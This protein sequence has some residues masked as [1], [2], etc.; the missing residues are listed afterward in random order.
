MVMER[1]DDMN[2]NEIAKSGKPTPCVFNFESAIQMRK[3]CDKNTQHIIDNLL[4]AICVDNQLDVEK[5]PSSELPDEEWEI[6][7][8]RISSLKQLNQLEKQSIKQFGEIAKHA[9][10]IPAIATA[11]KKSMQIY[12]HAKSVVSSDRGYEIEDLIRYNAWFSKF[13]KGI[14]KALRYLRYMEKFY[15]FKRS[16][17]LKNRPASDPRST[18]TAFPRPNSDVN[19]VRPLPESSTS[20]PPTSSSSRSESASIA[21]VSYNV[22]DGSMGAKFREINRVIQSSNQSANPTPRT[23]APRL[24]PSTTNTEPVTAPEQSKTTSK[25]KRN[26]EKWTDDDYDAI[27]DMT[28]QGYEVEEIAK[29]MNRS[30]ASIRIKVWQ[31]EHDTDARARRIKLRRQSPEE[32]ATQSA[33]ASASAPTGSED[34]TGVDWTHEEETLLRNLALQQVPNHEIAQKMSRSWRSIVLKKSRMGLP[35]RTRKRA[36]VSGSPKSTDGDRSTTNHESNGIGNVVATDKDD[37]EDTSAETA[38]E[39][40]D[41]SPLHS[42][43]EERIFASQSDAQDA[44]ANCIA[45]YVG[46]M[47]PNP[48]NNENTEQSTEDPTPMD[49]V[50][51]S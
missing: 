11:A 49:T 36:R 22:P 51:T 30:I 34:R 41:G 39:S 32:S 48:S 1:S 16:E 28:E 43:D 26:Y 13:C 2:T 50:A 47:A 33:S 23:L 29:E 19:S 5:N 27:I 10:R 20:C 42:Q 46:E 6:M 3:R 8:T 25:R 9:N 17:D 44:M 15:D 14:T 38:S 45:P 35:S 31:I 18:S 12:G 40:E 7:G 4:V 21:R 24:T 37:E